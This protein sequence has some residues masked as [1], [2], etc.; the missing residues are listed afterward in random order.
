[1]LGTQ[2]CFSYTV[3]PPL[4]TIPAAAAREPSRTQTWRRAPSNGDPAQLESAKT[5]MTAVHL[6]CS[7]VLCEH[8]PGVKNARPAC[9]A[10]IPCARLSGCHR[11]Q[12]MHGIQT[13]TQ[14]A[15]GL[16]CTQH[17]GGKNG[18]IL[19]M[20]R[21]MVKLSSPAA[22]RRSAPSFPPKDQITA[23]EPGQLCHKTNLP[24]GLQSPHS[25]RLLPHPSTA[26]TGTVWAH[27]PQLE[28]N[29]SCLNSGWAGNAK[30]WTLLPPLVRATIGGQ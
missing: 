12:Q 25:L 11:R 7:S 15:G 2:D 3:K 14:G 18:A 16:Q 24:L 29:P 4:E 17:A 5:K 1:M 20:G 8:R 6:K 13:A 28:L 9:K 23:A 21:I 30:S 26:I 22:R 10:P 19:S 27:A